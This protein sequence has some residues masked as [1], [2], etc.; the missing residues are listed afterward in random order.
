MSPACDCCGESV[1]KLQQQV[2]VMRKEIKNL[3]QMLDSA[4]RAHRKH[5]TSIQSAVSKIEHCEAEEHL[6]PPPPPP[7]PPASPQAALEQGNIQTVPIGY[8]SSCFSVKNGT[9]RQPTVCGPSRAELHIQQSVFNNPK[10][11]LVGLEQYSHVWVIFLFHKNGHLSYKAKVKPPRLNGQR[12][13][14]YSTRSPHRP[15]ALGLT[16]AKLDKVVGD[17]I[18]LSDIDMIAGTPVL[19]IKPYIPEYDSPQ[20]RTRMELEPCELNTHRPNATAM[21]GSHILDLP[22]G[23]ETDGQSDLKGERTDCDD[24]E[25]KLPKDKSEGDISSKVGAQFPLPKA[26]RGVLEEVKAYVTQGEEQVPDSPIN[27]PSESTVDRP[28][29]GEEACSTIA[30]WIREPLVASLGVRFTPHAEKELAEFLPAHLSGSPESVRPRFKFLRSSEEAAAAIRGVLSADP[31]SVY[32]RTRCG[33]RL[34]F[35]TLDTADITCWFGQGFAEVLQVRPVQC[36]IATTCTDTMSSRK[37]SSSE[38]RLPSSKYGE[39]TPLRSLENEMLHLSTPSSGLKLSADAVKTT[40][41]DVPLCEPVPY[42]HYSPSIKVIKTCAP[43]NDVTTAEADCG[44]GDVTFKS[45]VC[46]GG[47]VE[48]SGSPVCADQSIVLPY[49]QATSNTEAEDA[50]ISDSMIVQS[51]GDH[52]EHPYYSPEMMEASSVDTDAAC[53]WEI[54]N[55]TPASGSLDDKHAPHDSGASEHDCCGER[56]VALKSFVCDK[57]E[58]ETADVTRPQDDTQTQLGESLQDISVNSTYFSDY[59]QL[60]Q[61]EHA[62]HPNRG[63]V[64]GIP[65]IASFFET[66][67]AFDECANELSD[68]TF[69]SF[70]CT[71]GEIEISDGTKLVNETVPLPADYTVTSSVSYSYSINQ[72]VFGEDH[73][74]HNN[75]DHLDHPYCNAESC[76]STSGG[77][78]SIAQEP[79]SCSRGAIDEVEKISLVAP[80]SQTGRQEDVA[81]GSFIKAEDRVEKTNDTTLSG[82]T[83]PLPHGQAV[84]CQPLDDNT[85]HASVTQHQIQEGQQHLAHVSQ[86]HLSSGPRESSEAKDSAL[87]SSENG[88]VLCKST[89]TLHAEILPNV[90]RALSECPSLASALQF[91]I[92]SPVARRTSPPAL[93]AHNDPAQDHFFADDSAFDGEKSLVAPAD[94]SGLWAENLES[95]M[96][97]PLFNSTTLGC[98]SQTGPVTK[99]EKGLGIKPCAM[100]LS[101]LEK[102]VLDF[103]MIPD[104]PLQQQLRQ[105]AEFLI[106]ASGKMGP[107]GV[108]APA[109]P[110]AAVTVPSV[111]SPAESHSVCVGT[112]AVEMVDHSLNTSGQFERKRNFTL[113]DSCTLTDP[114]LWNVPPG[115]LECLPRQ[116]LEQRLRSSM[117]MVEALVQQLAAART[118]SCDS[119]GPA[120]SELR[121]KL[122]QT[123]HT[124]LSQTTMYRDLYMEALSRISELERDGSSV[125]NL[126]QCMQDMRVTMT[127]LTS[128]TD[129]ALS[130]MKEMGD[131]VRDD[132]QSLVSHYGQMKALFEKTKETQTRRMQKVKDALHQRNEMRTQME[133]A[134]TAKEAAFSAMEQLRTHCAAEMSELE[135]SVGSQQELLDALNQAY[136]EQVALNQVY[137]ET[138]NTASNLLSETMEEQSSLMKELCTLRSL[139]QKTSP[140][141]LK[142]NDKTATA[143]RERDEHIS[144]RDQAV[145][146]REQIEEDLNQTNLN[147]QTAREQIGDLNLQVTILSSE[148]GVLRQKLTERDEERGQLERKVTELSATV[149]ST[150]A[151]YTF[152]EQALTS[153]TTKLQ[154]SWKDVQQAKDRANELETSLDHS[155]QRV[156]ELSRALA[157]SEEQL[158]QLQ[159]LS[160]AQKIQLRQLQD[161]RTQLGGVRE[162]NEFLQMENE[163]AREQVVESEGL[164]RANLQGLRER[165]IHCEDLKGEL[166]QL[167]LENRSLQEQLKTTRSRASETQL[168]LEEKLA[169]TV[170][171]ITLLHHTLRGLTNELHAALSDKRAQPQKDKESQPVHHMDRRHPSS[172]FVDSI[173]VALTTEKEEDDESESPRESDM[174]EP[175]CETLFSEKSAFTRIAADIPKTHLNAVELEPREDDDQSSV[176]EL[177]ADLGG[178]VTELIGTMR[179]VQQRKDTELEELH[180]TI[181]GLQEEQQAANDKHEAEVYE[182]QH[183]LGRLHILVERGNQA[184]QQKAQDEKTVAKLSGEIRDVQEILNKHRTDNNELRKEVVDLRRSLQQANVESQFLREELKKVGGASAN[185]AHFMEEKIRLLREVERLKL[186]LQEAEQARVKLLERAKRHQIIHQSNQQKSENELQM[187]NNMINKVREVRHA[188]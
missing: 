62:V 161:V 61:A 29:Y 91:G 95:P 90:L 56:D 26:L 46:P 79:L 121:E 146:D 108:F 5:M 92:F 148:M 149:S 158:G 4:V 17:T 11:A 178:T 41:G 7:P 131:V 165:N 70:N 116:E 147:L 184:L 153:E 109:P 112:T 172:S 142:L 44:L 68:V 186:S 51:C 18:H 89:E 99:Q 111:P 135:K 93:K 144:A 69:K 57:S 8:I 67:N 105:M 54:P 174:A 52:I 180:N 42:S 137:T 22:T 170:T 20:S 140:M 83:S 60:C 177:L 2:S 58:V 32:R 15:N 154:Q 53:L 66:S 160:E 185:P 40:K 110:P 71:G 156:S 63:S 173:M 73:D 176:A 101:E 38:E 31:R 175:Q 171:E 47:E 166:D 76:S 115:S 10:H 152:L 136:P 128:D 179:L 77:N 113:V 34:F 119:A 107:A 35:F 24:V 88:P 162:M 127:S 65:V 27:K 134:F 50:V 13:G 120:P 145:E 3:R 141:L 129:A 14:V 114:L 28:C 49:D 55:T 181:C 118:Q 138:L 155:E 16:L 164:L 43:T 169:Q 84:I 37:S 81:L 157:Q 78:L 151:S 21:E 82:K 163:L 143:L 25:S 167:Q 123:D 75:N 159:S 9:P 23:S 117:I 30:D 97:R 187:L 59:N 64:N 188:V 33:D 102:P 104:G 36:Q 124:E 150:L 168:E 39:R 100:P 74:V 12:V 45:F 48:I 96:P 6:T 86:V 133:E 19:D 98:K 87:G 122:V 94:P 85:L 182:L 139:L 130:N 125:Q 132:H 103:P 183:Q 106:L 1:N 126:I 72:S 80:E